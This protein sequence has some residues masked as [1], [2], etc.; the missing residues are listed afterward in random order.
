MDSPSLDPRAV[1]RA[2]LDAAR[3]AAERGDYVSA[4]GLYSRLV[5]NPDPD[6]HIAGLLGLADAR[7]R[8]D[9]EEGAL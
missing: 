6:A 5:G 2:N 3:A 9:D 4:A 7:Y 1:T 8:L